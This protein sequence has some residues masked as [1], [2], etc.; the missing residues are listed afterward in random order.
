MICLKE[1]L[2]HLRKQMGITQEELAARLGLKRSLI[3]SYEEGRGIPKL[4]IIH[5]LAGIFGVSIDTLLT[6][7]LK[8]AGN[9]TTGMLPEVRILPI[10]VTPDDK[11]RITIVPVKAAAGY[12]TGHSDPEYIGGLPQFSLPVTELSHEKT[13]RVFQ[14]KGDSMLPVPPE[15][16][17]FCEYVL[18]QADIRE[19]DV[20]VLITSDDGIVFKRIYLPDNHALLLKSDN[21]E[22]TP[23]RI[24][25]S[26]V[27]E[28]WKARGFLTFNMPD[29]DTLQIHML[30]AAIQ[31]LE[32]DLKTLKERN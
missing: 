9:K 5:Q 10:A 26:A 32:Q 21:P 31:R 23:Y 8:L 7:N 15:A 24:D 1:N 19:G 30:S 20:Y 25:R 2:R 22:Y 29:P 3:G 14:I 6:S 12:L 11:E 4:E 17:L 16:Y 13:Y 27:L 28:I 18:N